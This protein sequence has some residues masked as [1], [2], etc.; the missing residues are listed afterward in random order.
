MVQ[1][2]PPLPKKA[3]TLK[4][5]AFVFA[6]SVPAPKVR[7]RVA[8]PAT[9]HRSLPHRR[10]AALVTAAPAYRP[11][12]HRP[13]AMHGESAPAAGYQGSLSSPPADV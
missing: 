6:A 3:R 9:A 11:A 7:P 5:R 2:L 13:P 1:I 8:P 4:V 10:T 12:G